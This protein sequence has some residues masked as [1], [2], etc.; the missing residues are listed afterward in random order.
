MIWVPLEI[1]QALGYAPLTF[2]GSTISNSATCRRETRITN[3]WRQDTWAWWAIQIQWRTWPNF[4]G[5]FILLCI[6]SIASS[7][8]ARLSFFNEKVFQVRNSFHEALRVVSWLAGVCNRFTTVFNV[9]LEDEV[10]SCSH[11]VVF[12]RFDAFT[13]IVN[14]DM[15][16]FQLFQDVYVD[17]WR[18]KADLGARYFAQSLSLQ[19]EP[20]VLLDLRYRDSLVWI[21]C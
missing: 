18:V 14:I 20:W 8:L 10:I 12:V 21:S 6:I 19:I 13:G 7:S 11:C 1:T 17:W 9:F 5:R 4:I 15:V 16:L 2:T 3:A